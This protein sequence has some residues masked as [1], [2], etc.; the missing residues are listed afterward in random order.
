MPRRM[1]DAPAPA[2]HV[3]DVEK[4]YRALRPLRIRALDVRE[5]ESIALLGFD[6]G[7]AEVFVDLVTA[8]TVPD[9]GRIEIFGRPTVDIQDADT[10]L[11]SLDCF[12]IVSERQVVID[13]MTVEENLTMPLTMA[14]HDVDGAVRA[15]VAALTEEVGLSTGLSHQPVAALEAASRLR[16]RLGRA[17]APDPR[18]LLSE[19]PNALLEGADLSRFADEYARLVSRR[20]I[21][22]IVLTADTA[23][24]SAVA[25]RILTLQP[26][27]GE[28]KPLSAWRR[29]FHPS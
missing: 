5:G 23:F 29:L 17:L 19:H 22:S 24:A 4:D 2:I 9:T 28:L 1:P 16:V 20:G 10:W 14:L 11:S 26:A 13:A 15:K 21:T 7:A 12:G 25:Q 27:T 6:R 18:I 3:R 8:A